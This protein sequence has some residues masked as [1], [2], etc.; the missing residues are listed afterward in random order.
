MRGVSSG[1]NGNHSGPLPSVGVYLDEQP[2]TS[3]QGA[4]DMHVYDIER[5]LDAGDRL[6]DRKSTRLNS[7]HSQISYAVF[8]LK[9]K[10]KSER[11]TTILVAVHCKIPTVLLV[12]PFGY[13]QP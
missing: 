11:V 4:L 10:I 1:D 7:S 9:K 6:L 13:Y 2:I 5:A 8:C 12:A 3:I